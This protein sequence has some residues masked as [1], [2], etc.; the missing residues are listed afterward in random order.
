MAGIY[1]SSQKL[2]VFH[3]QACI[4]GATFL[5][6]SS[7]L[8][9]L[10]QESGLAGRP[11]LIVRGVLS[12]I[13]E[14]YNNEADVYLD[15]LCWWLAIHHDVAISKSALQQNLMDAGLTRKL[16][17][18]ITREHDEEAWMEYIY[19]IIQ[20]VEEKNL[21]LSMKQVKIIMI[22]H[23][24]VSCGNHASVQCGF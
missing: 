16:L 9:V 5:K 7:L 24:L 17:H 22:R 3:K 6:N 18:K 23:E 19:V 15:E 10:P 2:F 21:F 11:R 8:L 20:R 1:R 12:A 4:D 14:V 13:K